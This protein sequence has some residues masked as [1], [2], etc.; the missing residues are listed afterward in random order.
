MQ[1]AIKEQ[2]GDCSFKTEQEYLTV[3][4]AVHDKNPLTEMKT[5]VIDLRV[6]NAKY[7]LKKNDEPNRQNKADSSA[8][9]NNI[10]N[11]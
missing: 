2:T 11:S 5:T 1:K 7:K 10:T 8:T 3:D 4:D 9:A 6:N